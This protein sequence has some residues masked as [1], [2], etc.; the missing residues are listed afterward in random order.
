MSLSRINLLPPAKKGLLEKLIKFIF[1]KEMLEIVLL[2]ATVLSVI[3]LWSWFALQNQFNDLSQSAMLV[4]R[5][6]SHYNQE[7]RKLN[8]LVKQFN[9]ANKSYTPL[10]PKIL[11][12][13]EKLP[14][15]VKI[16]YFSINRKTNS[17]TITGM[18]QTRDAL[19]TYQTELKKYTWLDSILTPTSQL[20]QKD[21]VN[22]EIKASLKINKQ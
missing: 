5:E 14:K 21:N 15:N 19:L 3:L 11:E 22:F 4:N 16:N 13:V 6:Y 9:S 20:F 10:T 2:V 1:F 17:V 7:I 8:V 12:L 18:A